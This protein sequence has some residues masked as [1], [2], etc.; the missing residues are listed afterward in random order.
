MRSA[1]A[2]II[3]LVVLLAALAPSASAQCDGLTNSRAYFEPGERP[4]DI[5]GVRYKFRVAANEQA[6]LQ[7]KILFAAMRFQLPG[8]VETYLLESNL[9]SRGLLY[10]DPVCTTWPLQGTYVGSESSLRVAVPDYIGL[11]KTGARTSAPLEFPRQSYFI[12]GGP[13]P[14]TDMIS[15]SNL[16]GITGEVKVERGGLVTDKSGWRCEGDLDSSD[17][18]RWSAQVVIA[19]AS[20]DLSFALPDSNA[21]YFAPWEILN[22]YTEFFGESG[23]F[24]VYLWDLEILRESGGGWQPLVEW[25]VDHHCG[26]LTEFGVRLA[27]FQGKP[28][29]EISNDGPASFFPAGTIFSLSGQAIPALSTRGWIAL[30]AVLLGTSV[31]LLAARARAGSGRE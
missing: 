9:Y 24:K 31:T 16:N 6:G 10:D 21:R 23:L 29:I 20:H 11:G 4:L 22:F 15:Q 1:S 17:Y 2:V 7:L 27:T 5:V 12:D 8:Q 3:V 28:V 25:I 26:S 13:V 30:A 14:K 18:R 19:P